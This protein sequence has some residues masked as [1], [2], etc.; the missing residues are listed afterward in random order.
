M[1]KHRDDKTMAL[2]SFCSTIEMTGG[3]RQNDTGCYAPVCDPDWTDLGEAYRE[4]CLALDRL[5]IIAPQ[6]GEE[7]AGEGA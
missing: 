3:V 2:A 7:D 5:P 6:Q 4:A 1:A